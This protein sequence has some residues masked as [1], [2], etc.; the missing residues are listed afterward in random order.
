MS[1]WRPGT[2]EYMPQTEYKNTKGTSNNQ[3]S[4]KSTIKWEGQV[5]KQHLEHV[6]VSKR[7]MYEWARKSY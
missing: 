1:G 4:W 7:Y 6:E 3:E 5:Y 2:S